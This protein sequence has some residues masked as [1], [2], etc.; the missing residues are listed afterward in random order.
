MIHN[1]EWA[2]AEQYVILLK[3]FVPALFKKQEVFWEKKNSSVQYMIDNKQTTNPF[4]F[5]NNLVD[6]NRN[7][8]TISKFFYRGLMVSDLQYTSYF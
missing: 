7:E 6:T 4:D 8:Q 1:C 5:C 3:D 2:K